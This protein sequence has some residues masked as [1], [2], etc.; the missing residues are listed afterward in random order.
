MY[1]FFS[2]NWSTFVVNK[3]NDMMN[4]SI[5]MSITVENYLKKINK[6]DLIN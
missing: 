6:K 4:M 5:S 1:C 3:N 2:F